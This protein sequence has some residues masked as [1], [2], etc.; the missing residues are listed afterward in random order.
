[1][2]AAVTDDGGRRSWFCDCEMLL[3]GQHGTYKMPLHMLRSMLQDKSDKKIVCRNGG[4]ETVA[5]SHGTTKAGKRARRSGHDAAAVQHCRIQP[6]ACVCIPHQPVCRKVVA[7]AATAISGHHKSADNLIL[8][9]FYHYIFLPLRQA[10][11]YAR[12]TILC[13]AEA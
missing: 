13:M 12:L 7:R 3:Q 2:H 4:D 1:M 8:S 9:R 5:D 11:K 6:G 10:P